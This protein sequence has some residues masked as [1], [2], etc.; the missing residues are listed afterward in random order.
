MGALKDLQDPSKSVHLLL[1]SSNLIEIYVYDTL[2]ARCNATLESIIDVNSASTYRYMLELV[3][4]EPNL[5][6]KW[7]FVLD[8]KKIK[9]S[10]KKNLGVFQ[11]EVAVFLIKVDNYKDFK[12]V[13]ELGVVLNDLYLDVIRRND[14]Y[15]ML[16][17]Y[18]ISQKV[19][20]FVVNSYYRD[21]EKV[22]VLKKE[23][24]NGADINT[25]KDVTA[26]C[27]E[28]TGSIQK[29]AMQLLTDNPKTEMFLKRSYKKRVSFVK[30]LCDTFGSSTAYNYLKASIRDVLYIKMLYMQG[31]IYDKIREVPDCFD[32][33]KL[34]RYRNVLKTIENEIPYVKILNLY[35][36]I[37]ESDRWR[38]PEDSIA[39]MY[40]YYLD[41][42]GRKEK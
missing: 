41:L 18:K 33:K 30:E 3:N 5:A 31:V 27:G 19:L 16:G 14:V 8:Y 36:I 25:P 37:N 26:L 23:L 35:V 40:K 9:G 32:E 17:Q 29:L 4:I 22:F 6:D 1:T 42:L 38:K 20:E 12:E 7:L 13:K 10:L 39:F 2:K 28:S 34:N 21:P 11:S 15:Y 24:E